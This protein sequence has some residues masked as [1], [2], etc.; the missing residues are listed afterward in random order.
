MFKRLLCC[1]ENAPCGARAGSSCQHV[2]A[3]REAAWQCG[4]ERRNKTDAIIKRDIGAAGTLCGTCQ[5]GRTKARIG[6]IRFHVPIFAKH[7]GLGVPGVVFLRY[8]LASRR[9]EDSVGSHHDSERTDFREAAFS[10][11]SRQYCKCFILVGHPIYF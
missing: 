9:A 2:S 11:L 3:Y 6:Q 4:M 5:T 1:S 8:V 7:L 10:Q